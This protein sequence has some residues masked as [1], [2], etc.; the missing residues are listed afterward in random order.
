MAVAAVAEA[1]CLH[2]RNPEAA[3]P[4]TRQEPSEARKQEAWKISLAVVVRA[5]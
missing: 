4:K 2:R 1:F 3:R 5:R